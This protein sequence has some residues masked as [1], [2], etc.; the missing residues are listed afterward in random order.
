MVITFDLIFG[1]TPRKISIMVWG[2]DSV[3]ERSFLAEILFA[4]TS[5]DETTSLEKDVASAYIASIARGARFPHLT[6]CARLN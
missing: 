6:C 5:G 4:S 2:S 3:K 1:P